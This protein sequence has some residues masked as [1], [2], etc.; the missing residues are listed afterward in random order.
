MPK[1]SDFVDK[2]TS[3]ETEIL[4]D[5]IGLFKN[6]I[7]EHKH[8]LDLVRELLSNA[9]AREVGAT[10]VEI[11]YTRDKLGHVFEVSDN[12]CGMGYT[13]S[14][15]IPGR[16]DR[17]LGLGLSTIAGRDADEFSWKGLGSKLAYQSRRVEIETRMKGHPLYSVRVTDP[18]SSLERNLVPRPALSEYPDSVEP[19]GTTIKVLGH[20]P[21][22]QEDP[23][24]L[25]EIRAF[26][27][28]RTFAG[29]TTARQ[30]QPEIVLSVLGRTEALEFGFAE[31]RGI[32]WPQGL[33]LERDQNRL[34]ANIVDRSS[35]IGP[36]RLRGFLTWDASRCGL[37][38]TNLN[39]GLILSSRGIPY[40]TLDLEEYGASSITHANPGEDKTCLIVECDGMYSEMNIA[41]SDLV[42]S[43]KSLEFKKYVKQLLRKLETSAEYLEFR[44]IP[45]GKKLEVSAQLLAAE[46]EVLESENQNWVVLERSGQAPVVL[47]REPKNESE[48]NALIWKLEA[49][50]ALPFER[51]Q[52]LA[53]VGAQKGPDL[54]A[55]FQ[56]DKMSEQVRGAVIEVENN[57]YSYK[58][59]GHYPSQYPKVIC[60]D[61]PTSG[62]K[63]RLTPTP[64]RHKFVVDMGEYQV[65]VYVLK[66]FEGI[67]VI[68]RK[69]FAIHGL[70]L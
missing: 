51:F 3:R 53:Y 67:R 62:R 21:H 25:A 6:L 69:E 24:T 38:R 42:D 1:F 32:D 44:Q 12:G 9:C 63:D 46:K 49:L 5:E 34:I 45:I 37:A 43:D 30:N 11:S 26:L 27:L 36:V 16:L 4:V 22:R 56:E 7:R 40:F 57:F 8:P 35:H 10:R 31:F 28:H 66:L 59:H 13:G 17:F 60:W 20:P 41:R 33:R 64:R 2:S 39:T 50:N 68:P 18:W 19:N 48:V 14:K 70:R 65:H 54:L 23:F 52:S 29:F 15:D 61:A 47:M 55:M 58:A